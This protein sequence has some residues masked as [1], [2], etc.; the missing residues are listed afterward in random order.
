MCGTQFEP[1]QIAIVKDEAERSPDEVRKQVIQL[2][3]PWGVS[4]VMH[5]LVLMLLA[6]FTIPM[7]TAG[8]MHLNALFRSGDDLELEDLTLAGD[9]GVMLDATEIDPPISEEQFAKAEGPDLEKLEE[10]LT[11]RV[12][13]FNGPP[14]PAAKKAANNSQP[15][16]GANIALENAATLEGAVDRVT[17]GIRGQLEQ[18]DLL[19]VW[20]LDSSNSLV[21][22]RQRVAARLRSFFEQ[23]VAGRDDATAHTFKNAVVSFGSRT[24][25]R[26][27]PTTFSNEIIRSVQKFPIDKTGKENVFASVAECVVRYRRNWQD[28]QLAIVVW[29]DE[30][31]DDV[32]NLERTIEVC[33][34][35]GVS[36][37]V[38]GP[39]SVLGASTGLHAYTD[40]KSK[41]VYQLPVM[42]GPDTAVPERA[43]LAYWFPSRMRYATP[44]SGGPLG[45]SSWLGGA[46]LTG[47]VSGFSPY[48]LTRLTL[49]TGGTYTILDR[50]EDR[51]PFTV[52]TMRAYQPGYVTEADYLADVKSHPLRKAVHEAVQVTLGR[53][54]MG[55]PQLALFGTV[56]Q[57]PPYR[58]RSPYYTPVQFRAKVRSDKAKLK[59]NADR[60]TVLVERAL[61]SLSH[62]SNIDRGIDD[63]LA[64]EK[65]PRWRA[66]YDLTRGRLLATHVRLEEYRLACDKL[67]ESGT[68]NESTNFVVMMSSPQMRSGRTFQQRG[69]EARRLLIR[70]VQEHRDTPWAYLAQRELDNALGITFRQHAL[71]LIKGGPASKSSRPNLPKF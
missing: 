32:H 68:L 58:L 27:A 23:M 41:R 16:T 46:Q 50:P 60:M 7:L 57:E 61:A 11:S 71:K 49:A 14:V 1:I 18:G 20:L 64:D 12:M 17:G 51:G 65:S 42:R 56:S 25:E 10:D 47:L 52:E 36:V 15:T 70:C 30:S 48:A 66:W 5:V 35:N 59:R 45:I 13:S 34:K 38:V 28:K 44:R 29:T 53:V 55:P 63:L 62:G 4:A 43:R 54:N 31:G 6:A 40:P 33:R 22:D 2:S 39:S 67:A 3:G 19:V 69:D 24:K 8:D 26:V 21:D 37:S 9:A